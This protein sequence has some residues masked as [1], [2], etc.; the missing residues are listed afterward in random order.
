MNITAD[1]FLGLWPKSS[2]EHVF[3]FRWL[4]SHGHLKIRIDSKDYWK[5]MEQNN[6]QA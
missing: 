2:Y 3:N 4:W 5:Q 1:D 6:K